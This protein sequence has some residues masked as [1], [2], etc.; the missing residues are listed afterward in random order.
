MSVIQINGN[1]REIGQS[2]RCW[3]NEYL[4]ILLFIFYHFPSVHS[5]III[6]GHI[7]LILWFSGI[8]IVKWLPWMQ[9]TFKT[10]CWN[11]TV[12][13][14]SKINL[15]KVCLLMFFS[16]HFPVFSELSVLGEKNPPKT[17]W[18]FII[19]NNQLDAYFKFW[20]TRDLEIQG[21]TFM[22][23]Y[24]NI[25]NSMIILL[26]WF[27]FNILSFEV[28]SFKDNSVTVITQEFNVRKKK[29]MGFLFHFKCFS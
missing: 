9:I 20:D 17:N 1:D 7:K 25:I 12:F 2:I 26:L 23:P 4:I 6:S 13:L 22:W 28:F 3:K 10:A 24:F 5:F 29:P 21:I 11:F 8:C 19:K 15:D 18:F 27:I 16:F 14:L